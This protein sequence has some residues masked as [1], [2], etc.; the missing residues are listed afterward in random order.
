MKKKILIMIMLTSCLAFGK[1]QNNYSFNRNFNKITAN[2]NWEN[3]VVKKSANNLT[4]VEIIG[5][6]EV[7]IIN[8]GGELYLKSDHPKRHISRKMKVI[9][10][11]P[12]TTNFDLK[13]GSGEIDVSNLRGNFDIT[14]SSGHQTLHNLVGNLNTES[15]SGQKDI[16]NIR[17]ILSSESSS[18]DTIFKNVHTI[19]DLRASSGKI[20]GS[21]GDITNN[22]KIRTSSGD[23]EIANKAINY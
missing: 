17:G 5:K 8:K 22:A 1:N 23:I 20:I 14:S 7:K 11:V 13:T 21:F 15:S 10:S 19:D 3:L 12:N 16:D 18:G 4:T 2:L 9:V 6:P